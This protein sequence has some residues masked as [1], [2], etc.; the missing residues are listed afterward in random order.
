MALDLPSGGHAVTPPCEH[1]DARRSMSGRLAGL[2]E[3]LKAERQ[4]PKREDLETIVKEPNRVPT[5]VK[6]REGK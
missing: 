1:D 3:A 5:R 6:A 2:K 4:S